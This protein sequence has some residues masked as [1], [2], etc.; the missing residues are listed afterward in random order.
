[1]PTRF[2]GATYTLSK[3]CLNTA[4]PTLVGNVGSLVEVIQQTAQVYT[5][6]LALIHLAEAGEKDGVMA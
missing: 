1:V 5:L 4:L 3:H 2:L 6:Q